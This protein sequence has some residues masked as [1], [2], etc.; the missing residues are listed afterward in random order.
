MPDSTKNFA[1]DTVN[2]PVGASTVTRTQFID[3]L[4]HLNYASGTIREIDELVTGGVLTVDGVGNAFG[5]T[6][7]SGSGLT[8]SN[9]TGV[10]GNPSISIDSPNAWNELNSSESNTITTTKHVSIIGAA[11]SYSMPTPAA[12]QVYNKVVINS[13]TG[14]VVLTGSALADKN[15]LGVAT[16]SITIPS[17]NMAIF[18]SDLAQNWY[19]QNS[20]RLLIQ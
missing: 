15:A 6:L 3:I 2:A 5:R 16:T 8:W 10:A 4:E 11:G 20:S 13:S 14:D 17:C 9:P 19:L 12:S 18:Y 1:V 7:S